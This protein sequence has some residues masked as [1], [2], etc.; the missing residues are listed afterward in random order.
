MDFEVSAK[1]QDLQKQVNAF[2]DAHVYP[3]E[4]AYRDEMEA[5]TRA[6]N[7][8]QALQ[9]VEK[10]KAKAKSAGLWNLFLPEIGRAHV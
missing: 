4:A 6:G 10:L 5:N 3:G 9:T 8:W 2:M 7:R 1:T